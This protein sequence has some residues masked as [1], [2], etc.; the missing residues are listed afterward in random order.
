MYYAFISLKGES[1]PIASKVEGKTFLTITSSKLKIQA[2][3]QETR[4]IHALTVKEL[5]DEQAKEKR[6]NIPEAINP[7]LA[8]FEEI[9]P[10]ELS[11]TLPSMRD[12]Q[13]QIDLVA[14][15]NLPNLPHYQMSLN[16]SEILKEKV[17][18]LLRNGQIQE[19]FKFLCSSDMIDSKEGWQLAIYVN[20]C[21]IN[22]IIVG[23]KFLIPHL[24]DMLDQLHRVS[25][26]MKIDFRS[27]YH[28]I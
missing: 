12:I 9:L 22:K 2:E 17:K 15:A 20:N 25:I 21:A 18:E 11:Y 24:D 13:H 27:D 19:S 10:D 8:D 4:Q 6:Q 16:E 23:Y 1:K 3:V 26:F 14:G 28:H 7:L 5:V